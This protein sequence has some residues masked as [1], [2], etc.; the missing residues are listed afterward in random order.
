[1]ILFRIR[2]LL[3]VLA[4]KDD[5]F[6]RMTYSNSGISKGQHIAWGYPAGETS[7]MTKADLSNEPDNTAASYFAI[8]GTMLSISYPFF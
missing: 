5:F 8:K 3:L 7:V 4:D 2:L 6:D 1:M